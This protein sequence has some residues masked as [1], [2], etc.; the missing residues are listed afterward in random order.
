M[1]REANT[2]TVS[3]AAKKWGVSTE[4]VRDRVKIIPGAEKRFRWSIP[5]EAEFPPITSHKALMLMDYLTVYSEGG[6]PNLARTGL[7]ASDIE[8]GYRYLTDMGYITG[9]PGKVTTLGQRLIGELTR[10]KGTKAVA[11]F[12]AGGVNVGVE[13][14]L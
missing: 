5:E 9:R 11:G 13:R 6:K 7:K 1:K 10:V 14:E 8:P 12:N 4:I 3:E 2:M